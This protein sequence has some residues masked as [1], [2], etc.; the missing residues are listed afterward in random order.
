MKEIKVC[1]NKH[2]FTLAEV[3][4]TLGI[5]GVVAAIT[6]NTLINNCQ[7]QS[8]V[9]RLKKMYNG[10]NYIMQMAVNDNGDMKTWDF[11]EQGLLNA[12]SN[13]YKTYIN[14]YLKT[15]KKNYYG[16]S[17]S[18]YST[19]IYNIKGGELY[20]SA[21]WEILPDGTAISL[22]S[23]GITTKQHG[24]FW[25]FIDTNG[26][27]KPNRLGKDIFMTNINLNRN[28]I[29]FWSAYDCNKNSS[30]MYSGGSCGYKIMH[31]GWKISDDYPW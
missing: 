2:A 3:L 1:K 9:V 18:Y 23:N 8:T 17:T 20:Q 13:F 11:T 21:R 25:I 7:K 24:Y 16:V 26:P 22:F 15:I 31:D 10:L 28:S 30:G 6:L 5:I 12:D 27:K 14:P 19:T 4:I 29:E